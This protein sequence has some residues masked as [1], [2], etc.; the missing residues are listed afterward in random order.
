MYKR[1]SNAI[2]WYNIVYKLSNGLPDGLKIGSN[3]G[4]FSLV[5]T[6]KCFRDVSECLNPI[7]EPTAITEF[8][9]NS[10]GSVRTAF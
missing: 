10:D 8:Q 2:G 7:Y 4:L 3:P 6:P 5:P 1:Q 9:K